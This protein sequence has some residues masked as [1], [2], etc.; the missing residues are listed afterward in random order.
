[1]D[2]AVD[3][4]LVPTNIIPFREWNSNTQSVPPPE[5]ELV[6]GAPEENQTYTFMDESLQSKITEINDIIRNDNV[7]SSLL[8]KYVKKLNPVYNSVKRSEFKFTEEYYN[9]LT[10]D[11]QLGIIKENSK[12]LLFS[13]DAREYFAEKK[14]LTRIVIG[15]SSIISSGGKIYVNQA[16]KSK[17]I[18]DDNFYV[19]SVNHQPR[20]TEPIF[21]PSFESDDLDER[22]RFISKAFNDPSAKNDFIL[23]T[24]DPYGR[25]GRYFD[26]E[27]EYDNIFFESMFMSFNYLTERGNMVVKMMSYGSKLS[28]E[29]AYILKHLF[30]KIAII[31]PS[32]SNPVSNDYYLVA[33]NFIPKNYYSIR[34]KLNNVLRY[35]YDNFIDGNNRL[36][37]YSIISNLEGDVTNPVYINFTHWILMMNDQMGLWIIANTASLLSALRSK[38]QGFGDVHLS[39]MLDQTLYRESLGLSGKTYKLMDLESF[40][41]FYDATSDEKSEEKKII[42]S[43]GPNFGLGHNFAIASY[44]DMLTSGI[45][46]LD[47]FK[48][49]FHVPVGSSENPEDRRR[50]VEFNI[51]EWIGTLYYLGDLDRILSSKNLNS[52]V[53]I[54][55]S[56]NWTLESILK[57]NLVEPARMNDIYLRLADILLNYSN[58]VNSLLA[59]PKDSNHPFRKVLV[60]INSTQNL[61]FRISYCFQGMYY[62]ISYRDE[63]SVLSEYEILNLLTEEEKEQ[64][65]DADDLYFKIMNNREFNSRI[66]EYACLPLYFSGYNNEIAVPEIYFTYKPD[67][68]YFA[69]SVNRYAPFWC[70][71]YESDTNLGSL[72]NFFGAAS[73]STHE[74]YKS[75]NIKLAVAFPPLYHEFLANTLNRIISLVKDLLKLNSQLDFAVVIIYQ[76]TRLNGDT[77]DKI[78]EDISD[79]NLSTEYKEITAALNPATGS[80]YKNIQLRAISI[81]TEESKFKF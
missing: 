20:E 55:N 33:M 72:G 71:P 11:K 52:I 64:I 37:L 21:M 22:W 13:P 39:L 38:R 57:V 40:A 47:I 61:R 59:L 53:E 81:K 8:S 45:S 48:E 78:S 42:I 26:P 16:E 24:Q 2:S 79:S 35:A 28:A 50:S 58:S 66:L 43:E 15:K 44:L 19:A 70:S 1:M 74:I 7:S 69:S 77:I 29:I 76:N 5:F 60:K 73:S 18:P 63:F 31:K 75:G 67:L 80:S 6:Y 34:D 27:L 9:I 3:S 56:R 41:D 68:E 36:P 30:Y 51:R 25:T 62:G 10:I 54:L 23:V 4:S 65:I 32:S 12:C 49:L 46:R 14:C 17:I